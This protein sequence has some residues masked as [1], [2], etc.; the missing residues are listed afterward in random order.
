MSLLSS[1]TGDI[2][3]PSLGKKN[4]LPGNRVSQNW[5]L[6]ETALISPSK[7]VVLR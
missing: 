3:I 1:P 7:K 2:L 5:M 6:V 4:S